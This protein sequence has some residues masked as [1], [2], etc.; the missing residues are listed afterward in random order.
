MFRYDRLEELVKES[1]K[2]KN[3]LCAKI[4]KCPTYLRDAKKQ[5]TNIKDEDIEILAFELN[6]HKDYLTGKSDQKEKPTTFAG[7][8]FSEK[9]RRLLSWFH[10]LPQEKRQAILNLGDAPKELSEDLGR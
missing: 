5:N 9:D 6:T 1:G 4:G 7:D 2:K 8:E 10:S 3:Y